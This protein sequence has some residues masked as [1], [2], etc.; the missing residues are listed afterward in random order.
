M[1]TISNPRELATV[2]AA[3]RLWQ[4]TALTSD[5]R[6]PEDTIASDNGTMSIMAAEEIDELCERLN[7]EADLLGEALDACSKV[8]MAIDAFPYSR[9]K[10]PLGKPKGGIAKMLRAVL[11]KAK[12]E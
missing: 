5:E 2:L 6:L 8:L 9:I 3:L 11:A 7:S 10:T 12:G 4:R 1:Q